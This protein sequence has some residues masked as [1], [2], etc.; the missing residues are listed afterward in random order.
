LTLVKYD[1]DTYKGAFWGEKGHNFPDFEFLSK[2]SPDFYNR[3]QLV[4]KIEKHS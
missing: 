3:L 2:Y 4:A 1:F